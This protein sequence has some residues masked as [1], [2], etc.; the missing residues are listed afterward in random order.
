MGQL[1]CSVP[2]CEY[3]AHARGLCATH[4]WRMKHHGTTDKPARVRRPAEDRF[5]PKVDADADC[6]V[7]IG[8]FAGGGYGW[9]QAKAGRSTPAHRW[10]Y[11][12]LVGPIP[13]GLDLDHLCRNRACVNPDHLEPV[14]RLEN[15]RRGVASTHQR[16]KTHC[17]RSHPYEGSNLIVD[18]G[19]RR[20][21]IC[22]SE[23]RRKADL[24]QRAKRKAASREPQEA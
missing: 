19:R 15:V 6:W 8:S 11:E 23:T 7:W 21:R 17:P 14:T 20:C 12:F 3:K 13:E 5:W 2:N 24:R 10:A 4:D 9:F 16:V 18:N 22:Y 1:T